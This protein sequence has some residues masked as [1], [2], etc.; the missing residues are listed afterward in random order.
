MTDRDAFHQHPFSLPAGATEIVLVRHGAS[1]AAMEGTAFPLVD[2]RSDPA[3]SDTGLTQAREVARRLAHEAFAGL[4]VSPL[5]RTHQ[6][7]A[8]IAQALGLEPQVIAELTEVGLGEFEGGQYRIRVARGDPIIK[9]VFAQERWD[10]IPGGEPRAQFAPRVR[11]AVEQIVARTGPDAVAVAIAHGAVIGELCAQAS[12]SR[13][14]AFVHADNCS[15]SRLVVQADGRWLL[16]SFND[17]AH[18]THPTGPAG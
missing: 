7:A 6:T 11:R 8:P 10:A 15:I 18:L 12:A 17:I 13:P 3:L 14:F 16:R 2:G 9:Q 4:F 5:R 1:E